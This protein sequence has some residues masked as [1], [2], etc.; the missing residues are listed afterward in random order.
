MCS[1]QLAERSKAPVLGTGPKGRGFESHIGQLY[2]ASI[3]CFKSYPFILDT[4]MLRFVCVCRPL[5]KVCQT[6]V[7]STDCSLC[8]GTSPTTRPSLSVNLCHFHI[9]DGLWVTLD[10]SATLRNAYF[11]E[12]C[13]VKQHVCSSVF[14]IIDT[15]TCHWLIIDVD[16]MKLMVATLRLSKIS[17]YLH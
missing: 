10:S 7:P 13:G 2:F 11:C 12:D 17:M 15:I 4:H 14:V 5:L 1:G 16:T 3:D 6:A 8:V 9:D